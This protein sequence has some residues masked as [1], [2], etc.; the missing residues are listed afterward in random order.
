MHGHLVAVEVGV[1]RRADQRVKLN[2]RPFDQDRLEGL[3]AQAVER[4]RPVEE[5]RTPAI[6]SSRT[7]QTS[8]RARS[9]IRFAS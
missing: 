6:T 4:R 7:S 9:T 3:N 2:R 1:E 8:G 5:H